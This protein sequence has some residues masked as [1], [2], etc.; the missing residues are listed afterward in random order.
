MG[1]RRQNANICIYGRSEYCH[2]DDVMTDQ[3][4][5]GCFQS[6]CTEIEADLMNSLMIW[7]NW[8]YN[9]Q[10]LD[11]SICQAQRNEI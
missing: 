7:L 1:E 11:V 4:L 5:E 6:L 3:V 9:K 2:C 10:C 8:I